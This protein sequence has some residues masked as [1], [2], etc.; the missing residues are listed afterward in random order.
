MRVKLWGWEVP[1]GC[2]L[3]NNGSFSCNGCQLLMPLLNRPAILLLFLIVSQ[4]TA[5]GLLPAC[6]LPADQRLRHRRHE[7]TTV[8][9]HLLQLAQAA[10]D[11]RAQL[12]GRL[13][14]PAAGWRTRHA[15]AAARI[16][17]H[18]VVRRWP[19]HVFGRP[20]RRPAARRTAAAGGPAAGDPRRAVGTTAGRTA[21]GVRGGGAVAVDGRAAGIPRIQPAAA[22]AL[23]RPAPAAA[24]AAACHNGLV[25]GVLYSDGMQRLLGTAA[26]HE[27]ISCCR[28]RQ[29][30]HEQWSLLVDQDCT[31]SLL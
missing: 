26:E 7:L 10:R 18:A 12:L 14:D 23:Q 24:A 5:L 17:L 21:S 30:E 1:E 8:A 19:H 29:A 31:F 27:Y 16:Q 3:P 11:M 25:A 28:S 20:L 15:H 6:V 9:K 13:T 4:F 22:V 2:S